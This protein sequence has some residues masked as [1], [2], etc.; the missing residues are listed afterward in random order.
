[1]GSR[2]GRKSSGSTSAA[3][4]GEKQLQETQKREDNNRARRTQYATD[5]QYRSQQQARARAHY[6]ETTGS[7]VERRLEDGA[8]AEGTKR[9]VIDT[10]GDAWV[11]E[12]YTLREAAE[13]LGRTPLTLRRWI[14][15]SLVPEMVLSDSTYGYRQFCRGEMDAMVR[16]LKSHEKEY[17]YL[18]KE[19]E[20]TIQRIF[21]AV[22][23]YR[24][25]RGIGDGN[26]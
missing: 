9:E 19:H 5:Q 4:R 8:L 12:S 20:K 23:T 26:T 1:M 10:N 17:S 2:K 3:T 13:A 6:R 16:V 7:T 11:L 21:D 14:E 15:E 24:R 25:R 18:R 22:N